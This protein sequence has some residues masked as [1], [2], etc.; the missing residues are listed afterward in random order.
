M[1]LPPAPRQ[2]RRTYVLHRGSTLS[3][4]GGC[5]YFRLSSHPQVLKALTAGLKQL[6]LS[7]SSSRLTTGNHPVYE[8][9]E[10]SLARFFGAE[11]ATLASN[12]YAPNLMAAQALV[13]RFSHAL[14][15][16]RAHGS[17]ADAA[18]LLDCPVLKFKHRDAGD[19]ARLVHRLGTI[20]PIVL[21]DGMF[22]HNGGVAP[23]KKYRAVLPAGATVLVDDAHGA[24]V[25]GKNGRGTPEH[26]GV[27]S[28]QIIQTITL[29]KAFGVYGGAVLGRGEL[30]AQIIKGSRLFI[31]STPLP[32]PLACAAMKSLVV[33]KGD[34]RFRV[35]LFRNVGHVRGKLLAGGFAVEET[36]GPIIS[37]IPHS[38]KEANHLKR[39]LLAG[40]IHP[41]FVQYPG[42]PDGG[43][44]RF[45]ISSEHSR[46]QLDALA[47][48][49]LSLRGDGFP[50]H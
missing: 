50:S 46:K 42:G 6:G 26:E 7:V 25:L 30:R 29:S 37:L 28:R 19:L 14:I 21:T 23:L 16:E 11:S 4:F 31:G 17:L 1:T 41:P 20:R 5:D 44:F 39:R 22:A 2:T 8:Q 18:Q 43:H 48:A 3:Y 24:G 27:S 45:V 34:R 35:R 47:N 10:K 12:G 9:L 36:P 38:V 15:D 49:L 40:G 33:L 13:G 32:L